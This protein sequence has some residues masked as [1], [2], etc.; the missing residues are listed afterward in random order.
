MPTLLLPRSAILN[1]RRVVISKAIITAHTRRVNVSHL[2]SFL[3]LGLCAFRARVL[4]FLNA[5]F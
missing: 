3:K 5:L 1:R 2:I 4:H